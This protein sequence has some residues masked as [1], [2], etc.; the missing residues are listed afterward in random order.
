MSNSSWSKSSFKWEVKYILILYS[1]EFNADVNSTELLLELFVMNTLKRLRDVSKNFLCSY[2][3]IVS[4]KSHSGQYKLGLLLLFVQ[5]DS[6]N[7]WKIV[8][9]YDDW[10]RT[11]LIDFGTIYF[12]I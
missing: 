2:S 5:V 11:M 8:L 1:I 7:L 10:I 6:K 12:E 9:M 3:S 4:N